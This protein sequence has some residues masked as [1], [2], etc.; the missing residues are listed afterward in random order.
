MMTEW[1]KPAWYLTPQEFANIIVD[2][3]ED[4]NYFRRDEKAHPVDIEAAFSTTASAIA[5]AIDAIGKKIY[6]EEKQ[7]DKKAMMTAKDLKKNSITI[8]SSDNIKLVNSETTFG[9]DIDYL[10][11]KYGKIKK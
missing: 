8:T 6:D 3:L 11:H 1:K 10:E 4:N 2:S 9:E 5:H 7:E